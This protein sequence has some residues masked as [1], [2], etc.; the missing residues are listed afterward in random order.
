LPDGEEPLSAASQLKARRSR[1]G[2]ERLQ[3]PMNALIIIAG[4]S[5]LGVFCTLALKGLLAPR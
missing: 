2:G 4:L 3:P 5:G 1:C